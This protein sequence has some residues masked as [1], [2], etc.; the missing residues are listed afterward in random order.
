M[1]ID[2]NTGLPTLPEGQYWRVLN[3]DWE[4][5]EG[6][7]LIR[8]EETPPEPCWSEWRR[9]IAP[10]LDAWS[11]EE[12]RTITTGR[13]WYGKRIVAHQ[14]RD[15]LNPEPRIIWQRRIKFAT[16][17]PG[18]EHIRYAAKASLEELAQHQKAQRLTGKYPP[19]KLE[20]E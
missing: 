11:D 18:T 16:P 2:K 20:A 17:H 10:S 15:W 3:G 1:S 9:D 14:R 4:R 8:I 5:F 7:W 12:K 19:N 13:T 6:R